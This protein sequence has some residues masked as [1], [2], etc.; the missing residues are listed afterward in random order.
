MCHPE[1]SSERQVQV[2]HEAG[3]MRKRTSVFFL[4]ALTACAGIQFPEPST[5]GGSTTVP[6]TGDVA[7]DVVRLT[8]DA[9]APMIVCSARLYAA[10]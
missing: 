1:R 5:G 9:R 7:A 10:I 4:A 3:V 6:A 8:N 2:L